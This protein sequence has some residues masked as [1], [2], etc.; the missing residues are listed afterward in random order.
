MLTTVLQEERDRQ[1]E[2]ERERERQREREM[3]RHSHS[4]SRRYEYYYMCPH[5]TILLYDVSS[6]YYTTI[7]CVLILLCYYTMCPHNSIHVELEVQLLQLR[8]LRRLWP[9]A[10]MSTR[11]RKHEGKRRRTQKMT[12][13]I[14]PRTCMSIWITRL[15]RY[16]VHTPTASVRACGSSVLK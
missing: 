4:H 14:R 11:K 13:W 12:S 10:R 8:A 3:R 9:A 7:L 2:R 5:T 1:T 16:Y 15:C 6:Y